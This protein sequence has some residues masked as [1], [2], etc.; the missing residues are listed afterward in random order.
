[1][2]TG[3]EVLLP[4]PAAGGV[5][6]SWQGGLTSR[7]EPRASTRD[8]ARRAESGPALSGSGLTPAPNA[9]SGGTRAAYGV[10]CPRKGRAPLANVIAGRRVASARRGCLDRMLITG[11][12]HLDWSLMSTPVTAAPAGP[13]GAPHPA[14][15]IRLSASG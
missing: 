5:L 4:P 7:P 9:G 11:E 13:A 3:G 8:P 14:V 1:V 2:V 12:R 6:A 15:R 10:S